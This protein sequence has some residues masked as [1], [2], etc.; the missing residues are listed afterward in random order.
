MGFAKFM[1]SPTGRLIRVIAGIALIA[2]GLWVLNASTLGIIL[3][4]IG[5]VPLVAGLFDFCVLA[6]LFGGPFSGPAARRG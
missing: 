6:P 1:A 3:A 4:V 5:V 2:V